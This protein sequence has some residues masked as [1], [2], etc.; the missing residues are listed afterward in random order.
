ARERALCVRAVDARGTAPAQVGVV[1]AAR[2]LAGAAPAARAGGPGRFDDADL[3]LTGRVAGGGV[4]ARHH[5]QLGQVVA[6]PL[7]VQAIGGARLDHGP[8]LQRLVAGG[9]E[10]L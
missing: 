10:W 6:V 7:P 9:A 4:D 3:G 2:R 5:A 1:A 8:G